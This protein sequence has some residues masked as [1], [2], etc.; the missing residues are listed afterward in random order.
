MA[1]II[2]PGT[3]LTQD[4]QWRVIRDGAVLIDGDQI[5]A[6]GSFGD[7]LMSHPEA[8]LY[9]AGGRTIMPG[10]INAHAHFYGL[11]A[12][13]ISLKDPA[14]ATFRQVLERLWWRLDRALDHEGVRISA[15]LGGIAAL[16]AGCTTVIDHHA[17]P[18][19]IDGSLDQVAQATERLGLRAC[20][21]YEV[22][23]R[24][25]PEKAAAGIA[26]NVRFARSLGARA[27]G[28]GPGAGPVPRLAAKFGLHA[29]FTLLDSTL[30][31]A[32]R[33]EADLGLGFHIHCAEGPEDRG[34]PARLH[35]AGILGPA[36][37]VAHSVHIDE[38]DMA[39]LAETGTT[40][41]HQPHSNMGNAVG[42]SRVADMAARGV[43][44]ALGTDG[45]TFDMLESMRTA[46]ALHAHETGRPGAGV[47]E[48]AKVMLRGNAALASAIFGR[49]VGALAPGATAD[50]ILL[51]YFPPTPIDAGNLPWHLQFGLSAPQVQTVWVGGR[52]VLEA[53][54]VPAVDEIAL[55]RRA[56]DV[57][58]ATWERF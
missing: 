43:R 18:N 22:S 34:A 47:A 56:L 26:E 55:A 21:C 45:Y 44:T 17:S 37:L 2:G 30:A 24:D 50:I 49:R 46:A 32:R 58:A 38:A 53:R 39:L 52:R 11:F 8:K 23:D 54:E 25:G 51:D 6:V 13:G 14:P 36:T 35:Q 28:A 9:D 31:A 12:R 48:F 33:A 27:G 3:V 42:W 1:W 29:A 16:R 7:L 5:L 20:L 4:D 10:L 15:L 40:V 19:C 57:A 41:S